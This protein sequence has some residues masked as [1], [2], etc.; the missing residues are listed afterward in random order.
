MKKPN[1]CEFNGREPGVPTRASP[2][3]RGGADRS[4]LKFRLAA[5]DERLLMVK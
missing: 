4:H 2:L 1:K 3:A 5:F